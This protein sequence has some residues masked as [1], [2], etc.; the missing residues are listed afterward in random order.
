MRLTVA[1]CSTYGFSINLET[2]LTAQAMSGRVAV[3][4][5]ISAPTASWNSAFTLV[6]VSLGRSFELMSVWLI[7]A[8]QSSLPERMRMSSM[9]RRYYFVT[10]PSSLSTSSTPNTNAKLP[11]SVNIKRP[12]KSV[13][14]RAISSVELFFQWLTHH[15]R[16]PAIARNALQQSWCRGMGRTPKL[17]SQSS[18][19]TRQKS[20]SIH[21]KPVSDHKLSWPAQDS[22]S[23]FELDPFWCYTVHNFF[24]DSIKKSRYHI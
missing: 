10:L 24:H 6:G 22:Q 3:I 14:V 13:F 18:I 8:L 9:Y 20:R 11:L 17:E 5:C 12:F 2:Y 4:R 16:I 19:Q 15:R 1:Q 7:T 23:L 21:A